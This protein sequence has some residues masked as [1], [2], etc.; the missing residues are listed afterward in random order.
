MH[1]LRDAAVPGVY[2]FDEAQHKGHPLG[3]K[4]SAQL[5]P[6]HGGQGQQH[7][8]VYARN[9]QLFA[10][11]IDGTAHDKSHGVQ[12]PNKV[13]AAIR[14]HFPS[15]TIPANNLIEYANDDAEIAAIASLLQE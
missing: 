13:A 7:I 12:I 3:G 14:Q 15:F 9:N 10:L 4:Y 2:V 11:N 6:P 1:L 8:H 5:H